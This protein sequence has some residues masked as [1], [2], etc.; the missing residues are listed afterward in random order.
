MTKQRRYFSGPEKVAAL[1][2]HLIERL[3]AATVGGTSRWS[4]RTDWFLC[5]QVCNVF[6][7][8]AARL[9]LWSSPL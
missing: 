1:K 2:R 5:L 6:A 4:S 3:Y 8:H 9:S 7:Q